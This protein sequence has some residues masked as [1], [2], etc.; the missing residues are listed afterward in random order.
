MPAALLLVVAC[1]TK[2]AV[3]VP[4]ITR[5][6]P[7][8]CA[9]TTPGEDAAAWQ[10]VSTDQ[11]TLCLPKHWKV[12]GQ[13]ASFGDATMSWGAGEPVVERVPFTVVRVSRGTAPPELP[14]M[15]VPISTTR[16]KEDIGGFTADVS[17]IKRGTMFTTLVQWTSPTAFI[18]AAANSPRDAELQMAVIRSMRFQIR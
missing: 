11:F 13:R 18:V 15:S 14:P 2:P 10:L 1:A 17:H 12:A 5:I 8:T 4:H 16:E 7:T 9:T 6:D 3:T